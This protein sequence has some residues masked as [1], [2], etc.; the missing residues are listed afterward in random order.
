MRPISRLA[1]ELDDNESMQSDFQGPGVESAPARVQENEITR[2]TLLAPPGNFQ[3]L[4]RHEAA[5]SAAFP[6]GP[7]RAISHRGWGRLP[8]WLPQGLAL[9]AIIWSLGFHISEVRG[10][11]M[12]P[13]IQHSDHIVV[14]E[15]LHHVFPVQRGDVVVMEY[16][17]DRSLDYVKRVIGLPGDEIVIALGELWVNGVHQDEPYLESASRDRSSFD[18][19][20]VQAGHFFVLGDNRLRSSDSR[21]FGQVPFDCLRGTVR[22]KLWPFSRLGWVR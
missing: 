7:R 6:R 12:F 19:C 1:G 20:V 21:E 18:H 3:A 2:A 9:A 11:S 17:L 8:G 16:P 5:R 14:D 15:V 10:S 22:A 4:A 13:G